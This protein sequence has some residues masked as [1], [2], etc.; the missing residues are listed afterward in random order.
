[1]LESPTGTGKTLS[2]ICSSLAW[3]MAKKAAMQVNRISLTTENGLSASVNA[4]AG[5]DR[6]PN[7][8]WSEFLEK[9]SFVLCT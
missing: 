8:A 3:L 5:V 9:Q 4:A 7:S 1:M 2:L 6:N